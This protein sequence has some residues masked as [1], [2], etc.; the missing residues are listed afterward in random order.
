MVMVKNPMHADLKLWIGASRVAS[1][2]RG[3]VCG[4]HRGFSSYGSS[5]PKRAHV[6]DPNLAVGDA[7]G[8]LFC[9]PS[10]ISGKAEHL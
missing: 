9:D 8:P 2:T 3:Q 4:L 10:H 6:G 1:C 5:N 7:R